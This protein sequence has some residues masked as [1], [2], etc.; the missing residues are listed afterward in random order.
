MTT[1][2]QEEALRLFEYRDGAL[3]WKPRVMSRGRPSVKAGWLVGV[4]DGRGY[5]RLQVN[6]RKY[7]VHQ[8]VFLLHHGFLPKC[9]D[10]ADGN[11]KNNKIENLREASVSENMQNTK[12]KS[13][14]TSGAKGVHFNLQKQ[15]WQAKLCVRKKQIA[16]VFETKELAVEFMEL[17][18]EMAHGQ[19]ANHGYHKGAFA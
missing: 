10:H 9:V 4:D 1:L 14:N 8:M 11:P 12:I 19:F 18:R 5:M 7:Y 16:R 13:D 17:F 15:K 2:T 6:N 3:Y